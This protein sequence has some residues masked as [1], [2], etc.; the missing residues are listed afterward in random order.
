[1]DFKVQ[2]YNEPYLLMVR[3]GDVAGRQDQLPRR[4]IE[5]LSLFFVFLK[6]L[7][8]AKMIT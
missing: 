5:F 8:A 7:V 2:F 4:L 3:V 6:D 1:M